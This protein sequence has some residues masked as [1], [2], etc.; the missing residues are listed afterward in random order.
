MSKTSKVKGDSA[1]RELVRILS[2]HLGGSFIRTPGSGSYVGG[3]NAVRKHVLSEGQVA[4]RRGD[5]TPPD[6]LPGL[7]IESKSYAEFRF[8]QLM[9]PGGCPQLDAWLAQTVA[10]ASPGDLCLT[11]FKIVRRGWYVAVPEHQWVLGNHARYQSADG[12]VIITGL[13]GWLRDNAEMVLALA[14]WW[15]IMNSTKF[16]INSVGGSSPYLSNS[17]R[18]RSRVATIVA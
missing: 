2:S 1:E 3:S 15:R 11:C 4:S 9:T 18:Y 12:L 5:I 10:G 14:S 16:D 8:H 17:T 7:V 6:H 13:E